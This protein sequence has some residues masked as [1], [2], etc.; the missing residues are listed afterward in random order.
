MKQR[1]RLPPSRLSC[2]VTEALRSDTSPELVRLRAPHA[3]WSGAPTSLIFD[4]SA[5]LFC[6]HDVAVACCLARAEV[7]VRLPL[8][9][10]QI[11][12]VWESLEFRRRRK[13]EI[14]RSNR[15]TLTEDC[16]G[17]C[18]G[19]GRRL[20]TAPSQVRFLPPQLTWKDKPTG[21]GS[22]LESGRALT[23]SWGFNSGTDRRLVSFRLVVPLAERQRCQPSKL[24]RPTCGRCPVRLPQGTSALIR[25]A[26]SG[27]G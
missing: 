13:P 8:G 2:V 16:G 1:V 18:A 3:A 12:R 7:R 4:N 22:R 14:V 6:T 21:D 17:A 27:I 24:A 5:R 19:T 11:S 23:A 20:L 26:H 15:T 10:L 25:K 9:A